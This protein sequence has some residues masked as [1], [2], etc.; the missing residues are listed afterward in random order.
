M[1]SALKGSKSARFRKISAWRS[2]F[3]VT[4]QVRQTLPYCRLRRGRREY[5]SPNLLPRSDRP[6]VTPTGRQTHRAR[7]SGTGF[8]AKPIARS[9]IGSVCYSVWLKWPCL[10][11]G[12]LP[13]DSH[14]DIHDLCCVAEPRAIKPLVE[15]FEVR[16]RLRSGRSDAGSIGTATSCDWPR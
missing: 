11:P 2:A 16:R 3:I 6:L 9:P 1:I 7:K 14:F 4:L 8:S 15:S 10:K 13:R 12:H 5:R